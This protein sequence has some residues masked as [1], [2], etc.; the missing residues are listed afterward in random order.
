MFLQPSTL[1]ILDR[2]VITLDDISKVIGNLVVYG[3]PVGFAVWVGFKN[4][5]AKWIDSHFAKRQ[6][7]F[8]HEQAKD[9][10]RLKAQ[11]D[12]V[13]QGALKLQE[14]EFKLIPEAWEK[15]SEAYGLAMWL[16]SPMQEFT[17]L[18]QVTDD[19]LE[20]F[21]EK[22]S[23]LETQKAKLRAAPP[24][25]RD[26]LWQEMDTWQRRNRAR[27]ALS[28]ADRFIKING[29]FLPESLRDPLHKLMEVIWDAL[30]SYDIASRVSPKEWKMIRE[31]WTKLN[32]EGTPLHKAIEQAVRR[33]LVEQSEIAGDNLGNRAEGGI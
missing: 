28:E 4:L 33:R 31:S 30:T 18:E 8:E 3:A 1:S 12:T 7:S 15:A 26:Q 5:A 27:A 11:I 16:C 10:Q 32:D 9:L 29:V 14:R 6:K 19:E 23:L 21:L 20:E 17:S 22:S 25:C 24:R 13:I 2:F